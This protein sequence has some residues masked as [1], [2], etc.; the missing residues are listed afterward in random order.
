MLSDRVDSCYDSHV[1]WA[2]TGEF[3]ERLRLETISSAREILQIPRKSL[4][5]RRGWVLGFGWDESTWPDKAS[6]H[7]KLLD[8]WIPDLPVLL[9]RGDGHVGWVNTKALEAAGW[10]TSA[11]DFSGGRIEKDKDGPTGLLI[12]KAY[13]AFLKAVPQTTENDLRRHLLQAAKLFHM[14]GFTHIRDVGGTKEQWAQAL[15]LDQSG[16]LNL[17]VEMFF[18]V[19]DPK[20]LEAACEFV[21]EARKNQSG[22]LRAL[23]IK[24]FLDGSLGSEGAWISQPY[25]SGSGR[26][27]Q[28]LQFEELKYVLKTAWN[29]KLDVAV[30]VIGDEAAHTLVTAATE[31]RAQGIVGTLHLE[32][33]QILR[34][35]TL[36][37]M[38]SLS[39]ICHLQ[40]CQWLSDQKWLKEKV[41]ADLYSLSFPWRRLQESNIE[42]DFGSDTP[43]EPPSVART[44]Q[45]LRES[46][47]HGIPQLLGRPNLSHKDPTWAANSYSIFSEGHAVQVVFRGHHL[48]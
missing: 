8:Q 38:K 12:D 15:R 27:V 9:T 31:L 42:F 16:L 17:A 46:A 18:H 35:E 22:N 4:H 44:I 48:I 25:S 24:V 19:E 23:G 37:L 13:E 47:S 6:V 28:M 11:P 5:P 45:A 41:G 7:R 34:P 33:A 30:H 14:E 32:H 3:S 2:A 20:D 43:I 40:P 36:A 29:K 1:H 26:G 39:I 21:V 10:L